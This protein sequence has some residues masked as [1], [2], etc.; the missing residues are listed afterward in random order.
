MLTKPFMSGIKTIPFFNIHKIDSEGL[1]M[2][3][4]VLSD[5]HRASED[6]LKRVMKIFKEEYNVEII[7]HCGDIL[8]KDLDPNKF[9]NLPVICALVDDQPNQ[10]EFKKPPKNWKFTLTGSRIVQLVGDEKD[11]IGHKLTWD[12]LNRSESEFQ[13][14]LDALRKDNDGLRRIFSGHT[15]FP[16]YN[17]TG[18]VDIINPGAITDS[19]SG[20]IEYAT[21]DTETNELSFGHLYKT[22]PTIENFSV[23]VI[24]DSLRISEMDKNFWRELAKEFKK[25]NVTNIIHCG[26]ITISDIGRPELSDFQVYYNLRQDQKYKV[27]KNIPDNWQLI[28]NNDNKDPVVELNGYRFCVQLDLGAVI[29]QK[30]VTQIGSVC[31][32]LR[33]QYNELDFVLC[34]FTHNCLLIGRQPCVI[35]PGDIIND[36]NFVIIKLGQQSLITFGHVP[37][38]NE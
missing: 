18:L 32:D 10:L 25:R 2:R 24:S 20:Y 31:L 22:N 35:N 30:S 14:N 3:I 26:N 27:P 15:H 1:A 34:G 7:F 21:V 28:G 9:L 38:V 36:R 23:G 6:E 17:Q 33:R 19:I 37:I 13:Q 4:G 5:T 12:S 16:F 11:Y 8:P 29:T